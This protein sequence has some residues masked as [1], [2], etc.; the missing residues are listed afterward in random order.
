MTPQ[1]VERYASQGK[2]IDL[3]KQTD[4]LNSSQYFHTGMINEELAAAIKKHNGVAQLI[5]SLSELSE[6]QSRNI[7]S[8]LMLP[9]LVDSLAASDQYQRLMEVAV[10][11]PQ[12]GRQLIGCPQ[13]TEA[14]IE[15]GYL[16]KLLEFAASIEDRDSLISQLLTLPATLAYYTNKIN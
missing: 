2:L 13:L 14:M 11:K 15:K 12:I 6:R 1:A 3:F 4:I 8:I 10:A 16:E 9:S 5:H 7:L